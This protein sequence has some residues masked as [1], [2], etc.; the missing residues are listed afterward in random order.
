M[1]WDR[2]IEVNREALE[3]VLVMLICMAGLRRA[4]LHPGDAGRTTLPRHLH[5]A[6]LRLLRPAESAMRRLVIII[7]RGL[8]VAPRD[9]PGGCF[10]RAPGRTF[11]AHNALNDAQGQ[12]KC[13]LPLCDPARRY[14]LP[15]RR[16]AASNSVPRISLPGILAPFVITP[17][18]LPA[19]DDLVDANGLVLRLQTLTHVLDDLPRHALRFARWHA[20]AR[21]E[22]SQPAAQ[23]NR[24]R[25][26]LRHGRPPGAHRKG[27]HEVH[28][29]LTNLHG[30]A[31][32]A[33]QRP[34]TS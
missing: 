16:G 21:A 7:A 29:L 25:W 12:K 27:D 34:D 24:R 11:P 15:L 9:M 31:F 33:L 3:R 20:R 18:P 23:K 32:D 13:G 4:V 28:L 1:D 30:L 2:A 17:R 22:A 10:S 26:P 5:R 14:F 8:V 19:R 6:V